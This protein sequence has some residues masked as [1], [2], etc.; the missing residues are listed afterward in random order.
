MEEMGFDRDN[1]RWRWSL[2][3]LVSMTVPPQRP[4]RS[5]CLKPRTLMLT[6]L[7]MFLRPGLCFSL[8]T[9]QTV[10][11][12]GLALIC[13]GFSGLWR[14]Y[15]LRPWGSPAAASRSVLGIAQGLR[16]F[17]VDLLAAI[18]V[19]RHEYADRDSHWLWHSEYCSDSGRFLCSGCA[20]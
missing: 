19:G 10:T 13:A 15:E 16:L 18:I 11:M 9:S 2:M 14:C 7:V 6:S 3:A 17:A 8:A 5:P 20:T 4:L 12:L 1:I